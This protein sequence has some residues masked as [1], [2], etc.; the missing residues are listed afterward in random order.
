MVLYDALIRM[1]NN[2]CFTEFYKLLHELIKLNGLDIVKQAELIKH[3]SKYITEDNEDDDGCDRYLSKRDIAYCAINLVLVEMKQK[4]AYGHYEIEGEYIIEKDSFDDTY[5]PEDGKKIRLGDLK[6][7]LKEIKKADEYDEYADFLEDLKEM[8]SG[9][10]SKS[11]LQLN[12]LQCIDEYDSTL[13]A[14]MLY[15]LRSIES[16]EELKK[17]DRLNHENYTAEA[18]KRKVGEYNSQTYCYSFLDLA[19]NEESNKMREAMDDMAAAELPKKLI[20]A[21]SIQDAMLG[22]WIASE[23]L[24][25]YTSYKLITDPFYRTKF[26]DSEEYNETNIVESADM[27]R[28]DFAQIIPK[29]M[30]GD[31]EAQYDLGIKYINLSSE[32]IHRNKAKYW[33]GC[34]AKKGLVRA[35]I[36]Y[37]ALLYQDDNAAEAIKWYKKA[38]ESGNAEAQYRVGVAYADGLGVKQS[39]DEAI[40]WLTLA[41]DQNHFLAKFRLDLLIKQS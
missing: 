36:S 40:K 24:L 4:F 20:L 23:P 21:I 35:Q 6:D 37:G 39:R 15:Y 41:V 33:L 18:L 11:A 8:K 3:L 32:T 7:I 17:Y 34:S 30:A 22:R 13:I 28:E 31:E 2:D 9:D 1:F 25:P 38:A 29:A 5:H 10:L 27:E 12:L 26:F 19:S 14:H 16:E